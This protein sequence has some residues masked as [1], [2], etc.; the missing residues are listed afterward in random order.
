MQQIG[1]M[2]NTVNNMPGFFD[3]IFGSNEPKSE[4]KKVKKVKKVKRPSKEVKDFIHPMKRENSRLKEELAS[5]RDK[6]KG[7][8]EHDEDA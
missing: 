6:Q 7:E 2:L 1:F 4:P 5:L 3:I 8:S